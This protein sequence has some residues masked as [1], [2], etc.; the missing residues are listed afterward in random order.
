MRATVT[1]PDELADQLQAARRDGEPLAAAIRRLAEAG[2]AL[3]PMKDM[4]LRIKT[5]KLRELRAQRRAKEADNWTHSEVAERV[6]LHA[7]LFRGAL[8]GLAGRHRLA[9]VS[10]G[11]PA[12]AAL[13]LLGEIEEDLVAE[14]RAGLAAADGAAEGGGVRKRH[15]T[16][17]QGDCLEVLPGMARGNVD[18][19]LTD[20]PYA[21]PAQYYA[22]RESA[23]M[24]RWSDSSIM[25]GW[26][27][28]FI[29]RAMPVMKPDS[30]VAVFAN[31]NAISVF[32]PIMF[33][34][35]R[36]LQLVVWDKGR[37]GMGAPFRTQAEYVIIGLIGSPFRR[38]AGIGNVLRHS[39]VHHSRR[40][41]PAQKPES[42]LSE[43]DTATV[44]RRRARLWTRFLAP[45]ARRER[46]PPLAATYALRRW[47]GEP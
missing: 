31:A 46:A 42:L 3:T 29:D 33:E 17:A 14:V 1:L 24:R 40:A 34:V 6:E 44:P 12:K 2:L 41:H 28:L 32:W 36:A 7:R 11:V 21:M 27:R 22:G 13:E 47:N 43:F 25:M 39:P 8:R 19:L 37:I 20:P 4:D 35:T 23:S 16:M 45:G 26:W 9:L 15:V 30:T 5:E 18:L 10:M 38:D